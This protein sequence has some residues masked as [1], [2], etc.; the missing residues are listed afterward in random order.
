[1]KII[2][3]NPCKKSHHASEVAAD[4]VALRL[5]GDHPAGRRVDV[6]E[7][8]LNCGVVLSR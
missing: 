2:D 7:I 6:N 1:M 4:G 5:G 8:D 3:K